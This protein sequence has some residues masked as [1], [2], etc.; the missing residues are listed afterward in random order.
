MKMTQ[1]VLIN[2]QDVNQDKA[3]T[4]KAMLELCSNIT[5]YEGFLCGHTSTEGTSPVSWIVMGWKMKVFRHVQMFSKVR[6]ETWVQS[7]TRVR[8]LRNYA[9]YDEEGN[10][11]A[12]AA[13]E[14]VAVDGEKGTFLRITPELLAAF[15]IIEEKNNFPGYRFPDIRSADLPAVKTRLVTPG[16]QM[17]D[18][19]GHVHN[20]EYL[21]L[22]A[23]ICPQAVTSDDVEII[24]RTQIL[25]GKT[26]LLELIRDGE[27]YKVAI[28]NPEDH[29]LHALVILWA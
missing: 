16:L 27:T 9:L 11:V 13:G 24:Y 3:V 22:A 5:M 19:N 2:G 20:S 28:K 15:D 4:N 14:W 23:E 25:P 1:T 17:A 18:Y 8:V 6:V 21:N 29:S 10:V 7:Y 12:L 26:V